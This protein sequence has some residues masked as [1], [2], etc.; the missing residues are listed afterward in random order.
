MVDVEKGSYQWG[1]IHEMFRE[2]MYPKLPFAP[3]EV[4]FNK[5]IYQMIEK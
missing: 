4:N 3:R 5:R 2:E 1:E